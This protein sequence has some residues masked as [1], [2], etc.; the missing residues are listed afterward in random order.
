MPAFTSGGLAP[1][2]PITDPQRLL[3]AE[4]AV[5]DF[6]GWHIAP[7]LE[8]AVDV[9]GSHF[10]TQVLRTR[11]LVS[12]TDVTLDDVPLVEDEHFR[13]NAAGIL[14]RIDGGLFTGRLKLTMVH[15][16]EIPP[17]PIQAVIADMALAGAAVLGVVG[18]SSMQAGAV[19]VQFGPNSHVVQGGAVGMSAQ[20]RRV[21]ARYAIEP[22]F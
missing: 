5:R 15:G 4:A 7:Q 1:S 19:A 16:Y 22:G 14:E 9:E 17:L 21:L 12:V 13:V 3:Q 2:L 20:Q 18:A 8:E 10:Y 6:C 11:R